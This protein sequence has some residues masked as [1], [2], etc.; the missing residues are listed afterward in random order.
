MQECLQDHGL[1]CHK[2]DIYTFVRRYDQDSDGRLLYSDFCDAFSP[3]NPYFSN[4]L[5]LRQAEF[6]HRNISKFAY[7]TEYTREKFLKC[8]RIHFEI[9]ESVE[10]IKQRL[11]RRPKFNYNAAFEY[12]D[13][14]GTGFFSLESLK[15][16]LAENK[17]Y[18]SDEEIISLV[19]RF[20]R[21][22]NGRVTLQEFLDGIMPKNS[23]SI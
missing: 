15:K 6:I 10:L 21:N 2:D 9:E 19:R 4:G 16:V 17:C 22:N 20:D 5:N 13:C 1:F 18:P 8:F 3:I 11:S 12:L 14:H 23:L 7:F